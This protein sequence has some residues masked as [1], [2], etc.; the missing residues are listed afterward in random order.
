MTWLTEK[1]IYARVRRAEKTTGASYFI[2]LRD[3]AFR[4]YIAGYGGMGEYNAWAL[5][6]EQAEVIETMIKKG[7]LLAD[8]ERSNESFPV[9]ELERDTIGG[10]F[11]RRHNGRYVRGYRI[12]PGTPPYK[13]C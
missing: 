7:T 10:G 3:D 9:L 11:L 8:K 5:T 6:S 12:R 13:K 4:Y 1:Q 2:L